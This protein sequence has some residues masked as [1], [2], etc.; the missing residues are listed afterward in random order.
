MIDRKT[1]EH[2]LPTLC[3]M[4]ALTL[5]GCYLYFFTDSPVFWPGFITMMF[6]YGLIFYMGTYVARLRQSGNADD[7]MLAGRSIPLWLGVFTMSST[8]VGGG[9]INGAA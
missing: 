4:L 2:L 6:F 9:Y 3:L 5:A 7:V 1:L 8:W